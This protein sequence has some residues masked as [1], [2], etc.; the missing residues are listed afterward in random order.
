MFESVFPCELENPTRWPSTDIRSFTTTNTVVYSLL[1][2]V[3]GNVNKFNFN[4]E[5]L[6]KFTI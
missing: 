5:F 6:L 2:V 3:L 1:S 4:F